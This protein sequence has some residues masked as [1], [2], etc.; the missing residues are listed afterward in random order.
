MKGMVFTAG[1][2]MYVKDFKDHAD[3]EK[4]LGGYVERVHPKGL[5]SPLVMLVDD[6]G[7]CKN[8]PANIFGSVLYNPSCVPGVCIA[9]DIIILA[10]KI[11]GPNLEYLD[12]S[13]DQINALKE[14]AVYM[15]DGSIEEVPEP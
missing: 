1:E 14:R 15:S 8:K 12:L 6:E 11:Q 10:E 2:K 5:E 9:G 7:V 3:M 13:D 4:T